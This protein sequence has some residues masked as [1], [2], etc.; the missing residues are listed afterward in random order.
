MDAG[1][2]AS[3]V[4]MAKSIGGFVVDLGHVQSDH[5]RP[6]F[7]YAHHVDRYASTPSAESEEIAVVLATGF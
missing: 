7:G 1:N 6:D 3:V 2:D 4:Q 5:T